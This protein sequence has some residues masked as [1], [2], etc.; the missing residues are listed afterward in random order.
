M[1]QSTDVRS[2]ALQSLDCSRRWYPLNWSEE[3]PKRIEE[4]LRFAKYVVPEEDS[5]SS[6]Y[7][8]HVIDNVEFTQ[9]PFTSVIVQCP[10]CLELSFAFRQY[11]V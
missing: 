11:L 7:G 3:T 5:A 2:S 10:C 9:Y 1:W 8:R 6:K 4:T